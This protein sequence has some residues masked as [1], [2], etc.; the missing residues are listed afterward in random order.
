MLAPGPGE[1]I[2]LWVVLLGFAAVGTILLVLFVSLWWRRGG[3]WKK[4]S[5]VLAGVVV[6]LWGGYRV[7]SEPRWHVNGLSNDSVA[8]FD[9]TSEVRKFSLNTL[10][11]CPNPTEQITRFRAGLVEGDFGSGGGGYVGAAFV[12]ME[13]AATRLEDDGWEVGR[14]Q[15]WDGNDE[16]PADGEFVSLQLYAHRDSDY[17]FLI[18][19]RGEGLEPGAVRSQVYADECMAEENSF[20]L[21][22]FFEV[23]AFGPR[24]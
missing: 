15:L 4:R 8:L 9:D 14:F 20:R 3:A 1:S 5:L 2:P 21:T 11:D 16:K 13:V 6:L 22:G 17:L 7:E 24:R 10:V 18:F 23:E 19:K 12:T